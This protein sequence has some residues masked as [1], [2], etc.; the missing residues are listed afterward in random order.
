M[1]RV[2]RPRNEGRGGTECRGAGGAARSS[3]SHGRNE[4]KE[5]LGMQPLK[6]LGLKERDQRKGRKK[7]RLH[8]VGWG[9]QTFWSICRVPLGDSVWLV[10]GQTRLLCQLGGG[11]GR[12]R[13]E[14]RLEKKNHFRWNNQPLG[15]TS[16]NMHKSRE[17]T[18]NHVEESNS[19][20]VKKR[21]SHAR[22]QTHTQSLSRLSLFVLSSSFLHAM[23][24]RYYNIRVTRCTIFVSRRRHDHQH[25]NWV[26]KPFEVS[27]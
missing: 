7:N 5:Q 2:W 8:A 13:R 4:R 22:K 17:I 6:C 25:F 23:R 19:R 16:W 20:T 18:P 3:T 21:A 15:E 14:A 10:L 24:T 12:G 27:R 11:Y 1:A 9:T 26:W